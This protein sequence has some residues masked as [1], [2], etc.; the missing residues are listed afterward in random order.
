MALGERLR[1]AVL[2]LAIPHAGAPPEYCVSISVGVAT[3]S[4]PMAGRTELI[5]LADAALYEAKRRGRNR[6][7]ISATVRKDEMS[8]G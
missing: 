8:L 7:V 4:S 1:M 5:G 3:A 2:D 6:T